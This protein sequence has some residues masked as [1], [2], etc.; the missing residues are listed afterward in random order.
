MIKN[1]VVDAEG[2]GCQPGWTMADYL[3]KQKKRIQQMVADKQKAQGAPCYVVAALSGGTF[4]HTN[5]NK[6][7]LIIVHQTFKITFFCSCVFKVLIRQ[8]PVRW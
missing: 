4:L 3:E 8:L 2:C 7:E 6:K 5:F 1:F